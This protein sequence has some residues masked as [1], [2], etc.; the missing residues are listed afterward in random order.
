MSWLSSLFGRRDE[1]ERESL[2]AGE[3]PTPPWP[4]ARIES[5]RQRKR[6]PRFRG[7]A[8][9]KV[10]AASGGQGILEQARFKLRSAYTPSRPVVTPA[11]FAGRTKLL[12]NLIRS[13]EDQQLHV[14]LFGARGIGKT[15]TLHI[16]SRIAEE[17][18]YVV[19]Y[20]SCGEETDFDTLFRAVFEEIPLLFHENYEPT[21]DEIEEGL[22]FSSLIGDAPLTAAQVS[23]I[24]AKISGTRVLV[25]LDEFDRAN[26]PHFRRSIAELIKNLSDRACRVQLVVAG[27]ASNLNELIE[28]IPSIRRNILGLPLPVMN[29]E[30]VR[31]LLRNG[32]QASGLSFTSAAADALCRVAY[33]LPYLASLIAQ[34][35][36]IAALDRK[37]L[38]IDVRDVDAAIEQAFEEVELRTSLVTRHAIDQ[39]VAAGL[40][41]DL[42]RLAQVALASGGRIVGDAGLPP[43]SVIDGLGS[44]Y[45]LI[46]PIQGDPARAYIFVDEGAP[47]YLWM[48]RA[49]GHR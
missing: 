42:D 35:A 29:D 20:T 10:R 26:A 43:A 34:H 41:S 38:V 15:S 8:L 5:E 25:I 6:L 13:I 30:E 9:D 18:R 44:R 47:L 24:L 16:L 40:E 21:A 28:H 49:V 22:T 36:G 46:E 32:E 48:R 19:R 14:V 23:D 27:V 45:G 1:L 39:A 3:A 37:Q 2:S 11:M 31:E 4:D 33:G 12:R 17:A 7:T